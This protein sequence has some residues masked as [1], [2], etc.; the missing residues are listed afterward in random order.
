MLANSVLSNA[1]TVYNDIG[2]RNPDIDVFHESRK[3]FI[4]AL[5]EAIQH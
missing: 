4:K 5:T 1:S 2:C 3:N